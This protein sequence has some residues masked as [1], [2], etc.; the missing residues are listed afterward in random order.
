MTFQHH[1][2]LFRNMGLF[3]FLLRLRRRIIVYFLRLKTPRRLANPDSVLR[4]P[5]RD[6]GRSIKAHV[7]RATN[8]N[9]QSP[10]PVFLNFHGSGFV[11]PLHG[12]DDL[13]C[14]YISTKTPFTVFDIQYRLSPENPFPAALYDVEDVVKYVQAAD[15]HELY[16]SS[17]MS[18]GGFSAGANLSLAASSMILPPNTFRSVIAFYPPADMATPPEQKSAP[19]P[20]GKGIPPWLARVFDGSYFQNK[21]P[22]DPRISPFYAPAENFPDNV[23]M[24]TPAKD[25]LAD[26]GAA[27][28]ERIKKEAGNKH[29][30]SHRVEGY[31]HGWDKNASDPLSMKLRDE[32]YELAAAMLNKSLE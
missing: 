1:T 12:G 6:A 19:D 4:I 21:D 18:I 20:T 2:T 31:G 3:D 22:Y 17:R 10:S 13:Y 24:V 30:V 8:A 15:H 23:L 16:D 26:E 5:S 27:L 25:Y 7:Y 28:A 32:A 14:R 9:S 29:V 11:L